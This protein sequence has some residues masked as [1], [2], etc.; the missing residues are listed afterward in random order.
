MEVEERAVCDLL[1]PL[2]DKTVLDLASGSGRYS[3][4][5]KQRGGHPIATDFSYE[6]LAQ[7]E[8]HFPRAQSDMT[9]LPLR[10]D[11]VPI[12]V[13]GLAVG[14]LADL[15]TALEEMARVL[16]PQ[17]VLVYSDFHSAG[18]ARGWKRTFQASNR[19]YAVKHYPR[20]PEEH[21]A[22]VRK[23]GLTLETLAPVHITA[24]LA[25]EDTRARQFRERWGDTPVALVVCARKG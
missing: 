19:T 4:I 8:K 6:M 2:Q 11:S 18:E 7:D 21:V 5:I 10:D 9:A 15:K 20:T 1:P 12:I 3:H 25:Q 24:Q 13:C 16:K 22:A 17:G 23:A 14:H